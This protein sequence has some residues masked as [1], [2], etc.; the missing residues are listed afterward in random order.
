VPR[1]P[2]RP[3]TDQEAPRVTRTLAR[4]SSE[5]VLTKPIRGDLEG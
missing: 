5:D 3:E 2:K 1:V 4:T